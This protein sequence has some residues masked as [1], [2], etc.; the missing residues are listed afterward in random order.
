MRRLLVLPLLVAVLLASAAPVAAQEE[1]RFAST[2]N[3][4]SAD[5]FWESCTPDTPEAGL[6]TCSFVSVFVFDGTTR[7]RE[8][9]GK[10]MTGGTLACVSL[11]EVVL[12]ADRQF[13]EELSNEFGCDETLEAGALTIAD[14]LSSATLD[15]TISVEA[16]VCDELG[17]TP[18][19]DPRDVAVDVTWTA[20]SPAVTFRERNVSHSTVDGLRC[21]LMFSGSG[22]RAQAV[23]S[24]TVD[25]MALGDSTFAQISRGK[26]SVSQHCK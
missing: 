10:P 26:Q 15:T 25:G 20:V 2:S 18:V 6:Q 3:G 17:C 1:F 19:G 14:D 12:T 21:T 8:G 24:G 4:F 9:T 16:Q 7:F 23:A 5:A 22:E 11:A 13:V